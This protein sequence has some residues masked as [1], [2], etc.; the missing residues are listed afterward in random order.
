MAEQL[1]VPTVCQALLF[2]SD[3]AWMILVNP[4]TA[5]SGGGIIIISVSS[6]GN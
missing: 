6:Q 5:L 4:Q 1:Q 3:L 2:R